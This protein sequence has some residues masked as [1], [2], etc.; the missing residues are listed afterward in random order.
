MNKTVQTILAGILCL[1]CLLSMYPSASFAEAEDAVPGE[2]GEEYSE[3]FPEETLEQDGEGAGET[4]P[5]EDAE[6][7]D[8][9]YAEEDTAGSD[10]EY[11]GE[12]TAGSAGEDTGGGGTEENNGAAGGENAGQTAEG[13]QPGADAGQTEGENET[14]EG[15]EGTGGE[16]SSEEKNDAQ[17]PEQGTGEG[18]GP[19]GDGNTE[20]EEGETGEQEGSLQE[21]VSIS[22]SLAVLEALETVRLTAT[23]EPSDQ[24][25]Q[26]ILWSSSAPDIASV[27][28]E[29]LVTALGKGTAIVTAAAADGSG[30]SSVCEIAVLNNGVMAESADQL[31]SPHPYDSLC[32]DFWQY[33]LSGAEALEVTFDEQTFLETDRDYLV[34]SDGN[35]DEAGTYTGADLAGKTVTVPGDTVRLQ[36]VS[37]GENEEWGFR[38]SSVEAGSIQPEDPETE[39]G[40]KT[41]TV[42][43]LSNGGYGAPPADTKTEDVPLTLSETVPERNHYTFLGWSTDRTAGAAEYSPGQVYQENAD[44]TL[45]AVWEYVSM[46]S[47]SAPA[48]TTPYYGPSASTDSGEKSYPKTPV[49]LERPETSYNR[50][51]VHIRTVEDLLDF[52]AN[53]S[54]DTWSD[55]LPVILDSDLSLSDVDFEPIPIFNGCFYGNGHTIYDLS[56]TEAQSPCGLFLETGESATIRSLSVSGKV[57]PSGDAAMTGGI[58]GIN[59]G[60]ILNCSYTG[61]VAGKEE[62]G[63]LA[64]RNEPTGLI[65]GCSTSCTVTG[66]SATGGI[67]GENEGI[68]LSCENRSLVNTESMDPALSL[69]AIDTSSILNFLGS[70]TTDNAGITSNTGG[71]CGSNTGF[72]EFCTN[73]G[74]VGY[75]HLGYNVGGICGRSCGY[76]NTC[77]NSGEIY[78]RRDTGGIVGQAEPYVE[79][80]QAQNPIAGLSYRMYALSQSINT[81]IDHASVV[82]D[83]LAARMS[84]LPEY[85]E[86]IKQAF[87]DLS[88]SDPAS[89]DE[90]KAVIS[91]TMDGL[92]AEIESM[93]AGV[94]EGSDV[95]E[96]DFRAISDNV[97][98]LSGTALQTVSLLAETDTD[99]ILEDGSSAGAGGALTFGKVKDCVNNGTIHGDSDVGGIAGGLSIENES[100]P[101]ENM[102]AANSLIRNK[103]SLSTVVTHC[104]NHGEIQAKK[105]CA[106]G[107]CGKMDFGYT[108]NCASYGRISI[109]D[110]TYAGG[111]CGLSYASVE[112]CCAKC[113][114]SGKKYIGGIIG[115]GYTAVSDDDSSSRTSG[116]Y[117]LVEIEARPQFS[118]GIAGGSDGVYENNYFI[119][120]GHAGLAKR[121]I[122]G[123]AEP[124]EYSELCQVEG[125]PEDFRSFTLS[126]VVDGETVK[127]V[128]F[129]YGDSF[130]RSVF[131]V[132]E[133]QDGSY[134]VWDRTDLSDLCFDTVVTATYRVDETVLR[135]EMNREDGRAAVYVD[136][137]F[138]SGDALT[139]TEKELDGTEIEN[140]RGSWKQTVQE[141]LR[142]IFAEGKP[143][144]SI[145]A[146]VSEDLCISF[147]DDGLKVH[148]L[149]YLT[150]DGKTENYR[151]YRAEEDGWERITEE[152]FGSY[153]LISVPGTEC[154]I[155]LVSTV[156]SWWYLLYSAA[157]LVFLAAAVWIIVL[158][159]R[160]VR[161][162][163]KTRGSVPKHT[164]KPGE[165]W[166]KHKKTVLI[167]ALCA[168]AV[169][170]LTAA[171]LLF[172]N[173]RTDVSA[174][175]MMKNFLS[176]ET[177]VAVKVTVETDKEESEWETTVHRVSADG[178]ILNCAEP[179]GVSLYF[180][181]GLVCLDNGRVFRF[182]DSLL[183][184]SRLLELIRKTAGSAELTRT[185]NGD[186]VCYE[187]QL[188]EDGIESAARSLLPEKYAESVK[189][190]SL[191][192]TAEE[193]EGKLSSLVI[194]GSGTMKDGQHCEVRASLRPQPMEE[195]PVLPQKVLDA[196]Q[197]GEEEQT[198]TL[199]MDFLLL[200]SAWLRNERADTVSASIGVRA[201]CGVVDLD[202]AYSYTRQ[203]TAG[204]DIH[205][206]SGS[207]FRLYF[208]DAGACTESGEALSTAEIRAAD[209]A[210]LITIAKEI[211]LNGRFDHEKSGNRDLYTVALDSEGAS[212]VLEKILPDLNGLNVDYKT[213]ELT[214]TLTDGRL[215][216][217][218]LRCEGTM[219]IVSRDTEAGVHLTVSYD[220]EPAVQK[221]PAKVLEVLCP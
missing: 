203:K 55:H 2:N 101:E 221:I 13:S 169:M 144:Y 208:S 217:I 105:E 210:Q 206:I 166:K 68:I 94:G 36:L 62:T 171:V 85:L 21:T 29:G 37:D 58:V 49:V 126:F 108:G 127:T 54:L 11:T 32:S 124:M 15:K 51:A 164:A 71:I 130:D 117:A 143:D 102:S 7:S 30:A 133:K 150:P 27:D 193:K 159:I 149:R 174:Y 111:I 38:V 103:Y 198:E 155:M 218:D 207:R 10:G 5:G 151:I 189:A 17:S 157:G 46:F 57:S 188:G 4:G 156:Q 109:E 3:E 99:G 134:A 153:Y 66:L 56:L 125:L 152:T 161:R 147:P 115:N 77:V 41:Y 128:S 122:H 28:E 141:Q 12:E 20:G 209:T 35:R 219:R 180:R 69:D 205:C 104:I 52:A 67:A 214:V 145:C 59:R 142:S 136:G 47:G 131:P 72:I 185:K 78:G 148:T 187:A 100:A 137:H 82:S 175:R 200:I 8:G 173:V 118:G 14:A 80:S 199:D 106:G 44:L 167:S 22:Q 177:D 45:Y 81:A 139:V 89:V 170:S 98:A 197:R 83:D 196:L 84:Y 140:F 212:G 18:S 116:C 97:S 123:Q 179:Y 119:P 39:T 135:S 40:T 33:T 87:L 93:S 74:A 23:V 178:T 79:V 132:V 168:V 176:E 213:N 202:S 211:C 195:R 190:E 163:R 73:S 96:E 215:S 220:E 107:I 61:I 154:E 9:E 191:A 24:Y 181:S 42:E 70:L 75:L 31:E 91:D 110:G 112:N 63:G 183:D 92:S 113:S 34:L 86:P 165:W 182:A 64:G 201:D 25:D 1:A 162:K 138:Q 16:Q 48:R 60:S 192:F 121:S 216:R 65:S 186:L 76:I 204:S 184:E 43:Y 90:T 53:C 194:S 19:T 158:L 6:G 120:N 129:S 26:T 160:A 114:L 88:L 50:E 172:S 146:E 95:L